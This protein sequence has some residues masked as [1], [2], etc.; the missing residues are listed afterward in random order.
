MARIVASV[1]PAIGRVKARSTNAANPGTRGRKSCSISTRVPSPAGSIVQVTSMPFVAPAT[2]WNRS[3]RVAG[4]CQVRLRQ[5]T[6]TPAPS[7]GTTT[8]RAT[9]SHTRAPSASRRTT[10]ERA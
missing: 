4:S 1:R 7:H 5:A 2:W 9:K 3:R 8:R 6:G 10:R